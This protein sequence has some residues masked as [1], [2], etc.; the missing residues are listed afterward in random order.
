MNN[1][2]TINEDNPN[3]TMASATNLK[4]VNG[5]LHILTSEIPH[6]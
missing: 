4:T 3:L 1:L 6:G 2:T 5:H